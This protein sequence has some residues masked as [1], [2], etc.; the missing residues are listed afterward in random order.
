M[1]FDILESVSRSGT[2]HDHDQPSHLKIKKHLENSPQ[3]SLNRLSGIEE[4]FCPAK[5]Y[6]FIEDEQGEK[7]LVIN[8]QNCV[9]CKTCAIKVVLKRW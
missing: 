8:A 9:H 2:Y 1:T 6:E 3:N 4:K 5:V 7:Q